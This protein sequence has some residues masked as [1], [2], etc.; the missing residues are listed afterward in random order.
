MRG[1][2]GRQRVRMDH[3]QQAAG[4]IVELP[5]TRQCR[6]PV[7]QTAQMQHYYERISSRVGALQPINYKRTTAACSSKHD[8]I[9][10]HS[11][12]SMLVGWG[13]NY[14]TW[15]IAVLLSSGVAQLEKLKGSIER[16]L[17]DHHS[18]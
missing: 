15:S 17:L 8:D 10:F 18:R 16:E 12:S 14:P 2:L 9:W 7:R 13:T 5:I 6:R 11:C 1:C 4:A 3:G